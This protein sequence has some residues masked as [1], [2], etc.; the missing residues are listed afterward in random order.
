MFFSGKNICYYSNQ[1]WSVKYLKQMLFIWSEAQIVYSHFSY[2][3][4]KFH[5]CYSIL[6][7]PPCVFIGRLCMLHKSW[8]FERTLALNISLVAVLRNE[9]L[10][11]H[12]VLLNK[13]NSVKIL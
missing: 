5:A 7:N 12:S 6:V 4:D 9:L 10:D 3:C 13:Y 1:F 11:I 2:N 8:F